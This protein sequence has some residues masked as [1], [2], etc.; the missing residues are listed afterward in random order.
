VSGLSE[1]PV[2]KEDDIATFL[3][4]EE[5]DWMVKELAAFLAK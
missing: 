2:D 4:P 1:K 3:S 5:K